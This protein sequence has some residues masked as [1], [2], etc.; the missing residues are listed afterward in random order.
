[1]E[2]CR[3]SCNNYDSKTFPESTYDGCCSPG[4]ELT[5]A[6][7][8]AQCDFDCD[9]TPNLCVEARMETVMRTQPTVLVT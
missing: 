8:L 5:E 3:P 7:L 6:E 1:M 4:L 2:F 9:G